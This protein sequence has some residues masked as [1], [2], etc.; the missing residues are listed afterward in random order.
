MSTPH[1]SVIVPLHNE[2]QSIEALYA[3]LTA[4]MQK[5]GV[6]YEFVFVDD[7]S[8]D[9][10]S[11][12]LHAIV[13]RAPEV[14][15]VRLKRNY[16]QTPALAAG[17][18][19]AQGEVLIT[20]DGDL[21]HV[22]EDIP[23]LLARLNQGYDVVSGWRAQRVDHWLSRRL[24]SRIANWC[25]ARLAGVDLRDFGS[26]FKAYRR[27]VVRNLELMGELHR[28]IPALLAAQGARITEV[29]I[30]NVPRQEG[31]SHYGLSRIIRVLCDFI[32]IR[33][34]VRYAS[35]PMYGIGRL[36]LF[37]LL[38]GLFTPVV[39]FG[40]GLAGVLHGALSVGVAVA[41][42][43]AV[44]AG[45]QLIS[46][47]LVLEYLMRMELRSHRRRIYAVESVE[48]SIA[49]EPAAERVRRL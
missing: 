27:E 25:M 15:V 14:R 49:A 36:G 45:V 3:R 48:P 10:T 5:L 21:Q 31:R 33:Y 20:M 32:T 7:G 47:G 30:Q 12:L 13:Q 28:F 46:A 42:G 44:L 19:H 26:T 39:S 18:D 35:S 40:L 34:L 9:G 11:G 23:L 17:F 1:V 2:A 37:C 24:L 8:T 4:T 43:T 16:G 6:T 29:P 41:A 38:G 22:P